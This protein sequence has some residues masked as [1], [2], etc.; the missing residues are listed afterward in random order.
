MSKNADRATRLRRLLALF[1]LAKRKAP[2]P[3][4]TNVI[5]LGQE[6]IKRRGVVFI[7]YVTEK[8]RTDHGH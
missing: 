2:A 1:G 7:G 4:M 3:D 8:Q 5:D 6:R